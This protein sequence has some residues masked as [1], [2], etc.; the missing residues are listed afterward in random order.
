MKSLDKKLG[1]KP[2]L[3]DPEKAD[4]LIGKAM[5]GIVPKAP[6]S[7]EG[8]RRSFFWWIEILTTM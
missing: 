3:M 7:G 1:Q 6:G 2:E 4:C 8:K 5:G